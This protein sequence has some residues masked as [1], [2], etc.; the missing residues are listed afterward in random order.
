L[1]SRLRLLRAAALRA[2]AL[3]VAAL[4]LATEARVATLWEG[5]ELV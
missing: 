1:L 4:P 3:P 5:I 2:G